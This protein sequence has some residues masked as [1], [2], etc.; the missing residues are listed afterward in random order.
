M[1]KLKEL[2]DQVFTPDG[3]VRA[4]GRAKCKE[5]IVVAQAAHPNIDFG[6]PDTGKMNVDK[7]KEIFF[8]ENDSDS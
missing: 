4:C 8:S 5:L 2:L 6:D 7:F 3:E 1:K